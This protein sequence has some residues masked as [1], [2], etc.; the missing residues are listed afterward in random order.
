MSLKKIAEMT[1]VSISTVSRVLNN[2]DYNC[3]SEDLKDRIWAAAKEIHYVP[4][5]S[6]RN[7]KLGGES[8]HAA[9]VRSL[10]V[11]LERFSSLDED[12]FFRELYRSVEQEA[13]ACG[14]TIRD[15]CFSEP[16]M[17]ALRKEKADGYIVLG[18]ISAQS[19]QR[20]KKISK[21]IVSISRNPTQFEVDEIICDGRSAAVC[22]MEYLINKGYRR[23]AYIGDCSHEDRYVGYCDTMIRN[24]LPM[25]YSAIF[26]TDQR[27][28]SGCAAMKKLLT[29]N[30]AEAVLCANDATAI[31]ALRGWQEFCREAKKDLRAD[32]ASA[33]KPPRRV[34]SHASHEICPARPSTQKG[35]GKMPALISIDNIKAA[36]E[37]TPA[38]TTV[39]VPHED[40]GKTA[41]K[42][43]LDRIQKGHTEKLRV[44][45]PSHLVVRES[46]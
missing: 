44:E 21:N 19:L 31:G 17:A 23:I 28:K 20:L 26:P 11:I 41:V 25:D 5:E 30:T 43:L 24:N 45:F 32:A 12:P 37:V 42:V 46:S 16:D 29:V 1:G 2:R 15:I 33:A 10:T 14:C 6:A 27:E 9:P 36:G 3:A 40:M 13:F 18:R 22:A 38:L 7:L 4:N 34:A 8:H 35:T 39:H